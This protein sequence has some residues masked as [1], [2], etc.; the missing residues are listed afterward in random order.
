MIDHVVPTLVLD[1]ARII[2]ERVQEHRP[3]G[4]SRRR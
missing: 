2:F 3:K 1:G 4:R